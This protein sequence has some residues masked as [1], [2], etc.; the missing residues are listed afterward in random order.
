MIATNLEG[1]VIYWNAFAEQLYGW[2]SV[3]TLGA[4]IFALTVPNASKDVA[5]EIF[6]Q[7]KGGG[8]WSGE[9]LVRRRDGTVFPALVT[10]SPIFN[11]KN[12]LLVVAR[13][14]V[15]KFVLNQ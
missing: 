1:A 13:N 4:N 11:D 2:S 10:D 3:E 8:S 14:K 6:S 7:M 12:E 15:M 9:F 5:E